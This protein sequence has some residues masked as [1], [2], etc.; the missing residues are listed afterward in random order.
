MLNKQTDESFLGGLLVSIQ[1]FE[2]IWARHFKLS[3]AHFRPDY[4]TYGRKFFMF[5]AYAQGPRKIRRLDKL[6][7]SRLHRTLSDERLSC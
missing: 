4:A 1:S 3:Q 5:F 2:N 6:Q 7:M